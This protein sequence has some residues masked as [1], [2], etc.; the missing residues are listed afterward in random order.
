MLKCFI[1][2]VLILVFFMYFSSEFLCT[3]PALRMDQVCFALW[4]SFNCYYDEL[5]VVLGK[6]KWN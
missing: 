3:N 5:L 4:K 6:F 2:H 1:K